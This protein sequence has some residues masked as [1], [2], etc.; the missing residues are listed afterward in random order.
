MC[1]CVT[2]AY[3]GDWTPGDWFPEQR[4]GGDGIQQQLRLIP[5]LEL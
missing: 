2:D 3:S 1:L 5:E 4:N